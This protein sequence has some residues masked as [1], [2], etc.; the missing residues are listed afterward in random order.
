MAVVGERVGGEGRG[1]GAP[2]AGVGGVIGLTDLLLTSRRKRT[3]EHV[4]LISKTSV[5]LSRN[6]GGVQIT[7]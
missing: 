7:Y 1:P 2:V 5:N 3:R 4:G 6:C